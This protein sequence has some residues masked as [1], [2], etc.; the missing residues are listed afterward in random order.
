MFLLNNCQNQYFILVLLNSTLLAA[1]LISTAV[2]SFNRLH[3]LKAEFVLNSSV[4]KGLMN[5]NSKAYSVSSIDT[6]SCVLNNMMRQ[7][8]GQQQDKS[9]SEMKMLRKQHQQMF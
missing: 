6:E 8:Q 5:I 7:Q 3:H 2:Y 9:D 1:A 4:V